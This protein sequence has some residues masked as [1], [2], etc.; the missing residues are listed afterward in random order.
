MPNTDPRKLNEQFN[1]AFR[2]RRYRELSLNVRRQR[3]FCAPAPDKK[4]EGAMKSENA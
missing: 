3:P 1:E 4:S 2:N